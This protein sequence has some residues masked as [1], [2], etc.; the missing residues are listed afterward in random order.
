MRLRSNQTLQDVS[1]PTNKQ[2]TEAEVA[3]LYGLQKKDE[4]DMKRFK[5][6]SKD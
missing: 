3:H 2:I 4:A 5:H 6:M 1:R